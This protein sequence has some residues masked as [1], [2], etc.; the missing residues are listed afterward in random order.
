MI[1]WW[2]A[3]ICIVLVVL[4]L[5]G[6]LRPSRP[7]YVAVVALELVLLAWAVALRAS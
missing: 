2:C 7:I 6:V 1:A 5:S 3:T 4:S